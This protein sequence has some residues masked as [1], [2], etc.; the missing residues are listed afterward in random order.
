MKKI[1]VMDNLF[2]SC[3]W[4]L[5]FDDICFLCERPNTLKLDERGRQHCT[6]GP[7][8]LFNDGYALY[9][10]HGVTMPRGLIED[11]SKITVEV[12]E[13]TE[14][15]EVRRCLID[16]YGQDKYLLDSGAE[17]VHE[18]DYGVL[19]RKTIKDDEDLVMVKVVNS[20]PEPDGTFKDYF[21]R[22]D[23]QLRP[24]STDRRFGEAQKMTARNAIASTFGMTGEVYVLECQT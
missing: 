17:K 19:Y 24:M 18:D 1:E 5:L 3:G 10:V 20:S 22:V 4:F 21:I 11:N 16:I 12:I 2:K 7:S 15:L 8:M 14:N 13:N 6:D 23:P 9:N